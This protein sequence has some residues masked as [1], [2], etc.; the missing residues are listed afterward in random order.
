MLKMMNETHGKLRS[1]LKIA[2]HVLDEVWQ[3][4]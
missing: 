1:K 2:F 3:I 4:K